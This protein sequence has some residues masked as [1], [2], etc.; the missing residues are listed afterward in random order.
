[1]GDKSIAAT[2]EEELRR[3]AA[4]WTEP[5]EGECVLCF[6][7]RMLDAWGCDDTLRFA[8]RYRVRRAP[9]ASALLRRFGDLGGYCDCEIFLN[10]YVVVDPFGVGLPACQGVGRGSAQPCGA[11][12]R[13][14]RGR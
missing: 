1:M 13:R 4:A 7:A 14:V 10:G 8:E 5:G 2:T 12:T 6:V 3:L 11:W 9:R